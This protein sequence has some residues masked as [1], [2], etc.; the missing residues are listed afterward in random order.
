LKSVDV[1]WY[2]LRHGRQPDWRGTICTILW[3]FEKEKKSTVDLI[4]VRIKIEGEPAGFD[5][6]IAVIHIA[7]SLLGKL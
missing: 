4:D 3:R 6:Q 2:T 7:Y 1:T 5:G